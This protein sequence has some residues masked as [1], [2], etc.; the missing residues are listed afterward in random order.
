MI[1]SKNALATTIVFFLLCQPF[2]VK[3]TAD[4][5]DCWQVINVPSIDTLSVRSGPGVKYPKIANLSYDADGIQVTGSAKRIRRSYWVP[6][7]YNEIEGWVNRGYLSEGTNC[8]VTQGADYHTVVR[9]DT[10][11]SIYQDYG[12]RIDEIA[13]WNGLQEP[14]TLFI[15]QR[16]LISPP[17]MGIM[18][19]CTYRIVKVRNND[20]L[21]IRAKP[22]TK[23]VKV[24]AIPYDGTGIEITGDEVKL[25]KSPW[26]PIKY[27]GIEGWVNH[28]Y[29]EKDC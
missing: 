4:G 14:Y 20:M 27:K 5:P 11:F 10:L 16:L 13:R 12:Y 29:L 9:G 21:W 3:A 26:V 7:I 2:Q 23:S 19:V 22:G 15:G 8:S 24:G 1:H 17:M 6:I 18:S 25:T 28:N